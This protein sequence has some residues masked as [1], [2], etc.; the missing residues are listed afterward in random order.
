MTFVVG[1]NP[2]LSA[3]DE[4]LMG[5]AQCIGQLIGAEYRSLLFT[6][7]QRT[8]PNY[9]L[10]GNHVRLFERVQRQPPSKLV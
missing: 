4:A 9:H 8:F 2:A 10:L 7:A 3:K 1:S 6:A 5:I